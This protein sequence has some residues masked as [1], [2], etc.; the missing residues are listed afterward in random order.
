MLLLAF[1]LAAAA[2]PRPF[3][4]ERDLLDRRLQ[5][6]QRALPDG[7]R[8]PADLALVR[9]LADSAR[10]QVS[11][12][13][14]RPPAEA[15]GR[16]EI[17]ID[18]VAFGRFTNVET[19]FRQAGKS[20]RLVDVASLALNATPE[21]TIRM[22][23]VLR[24]P[25]WPTQN[26][27]PAAPEGTAERARGVPRVTADQF[28]RDQALLL[29]KSD[30]IAELRRTRRNPRL[31]LAELAGAAED[32]PVV[33]TEISWGDELF[34]VRGLS[35][36]EGPT[37]ALSRRMERGFFRISE[38]LMARQGA[39]RRFEARGRC[40]IA[41]SEVELPVAHDDPFRQD[42]APCRVDRD[43]VP[44][45][46]LRAAGAKAKTAP[47]PITVRA[48]ELDAGD[49]LYVLHEITGQ[50]FIVDE[51][52]R[53]RLNVEL[54]G[55]TLE[56]ALAALAKVR[57][58]AGPP[59]P[60]RRIA[61]H[62]VAAWRPTPPP[63][64]VPT[65]EPAAT[66]A[67]D[68][69]AEDDVDPLAAAALQAPAPAVTAAPA[70]PRDAPPRVNLSVK[71][72][73]VREI[74]AALAQADPGRRTVAPGGTLGHA[75]VWARNVDLALLRGAVL[76]TAGLLE[77]QGDDGTRAVQRSDTPA[78]GTGEPLLPIDPAPPL[79]RLTLRPSD[80][81]PDDFELA[82][83]GG[84]SGAWRAFAY[85]PAGTLHGYRPGEPLFDGS[86]RTIDA[87]SAMLDGEDG[88]L[89]VRVPG[90]Q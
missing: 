7:A 36:G 59:G 25:F 71:R 80:L 49:L 88:P 42:D 67:N 76:E 63:T 17:T 3:T 37:R 16:G 51:D 56:E 62:P 38:F 4:E 65:A 10:L 41:G 34:V 21:D 11:A 19:F 13:T 47:G 78:A 40:P 12:L 23:A 20:P 32:R 70:A 22:T 60:L 1:V 74:L 57:I 6:V 87:T 72:A 18:L 8:P 46:T 35:I 24:L 58:F 52:V 55:V 61:M 82:A 81:S 73:S 2:A 86:V 54:L 69:A 75:T 66:P 15:G 53:Q 90:V 29:A 48:N 79:R 31:F 84:D 9:A 85:S 89:V 44:A 26:R 77:V 50:S 39:C 28:T 5:A 45:Q 14:A 27:L 68:D 30:A 83:I 43:P 33:L 64:P